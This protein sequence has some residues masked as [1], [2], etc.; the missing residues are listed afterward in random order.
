MLVIFLTRAAPCLVK[1][2]DAEPLEDDGPDG[3]EVLPDPA[4]PSEGPSLDLGRD[5][6]IDPTRDAR[7]R[8][9]LSL[10]PGLAMP[11]PPSEVNEPSMLPPP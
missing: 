2:F 10:N 1:E 7:A 3:G 5:S 9:R 11:P 6:A 4:D 8:S